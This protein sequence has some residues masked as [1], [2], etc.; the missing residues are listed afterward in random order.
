MASKRA[1]DDVY[2]VSVAAVGHA[3][4]T[5]LAC[6]AAVSRA[7]KS[8]SI[9][10]QQANLC[11][12]ACRYCPIEL[13]LGVIFTRWRL[14][15]ACAIIIDSRVPGR[16]PIHQHDFELMASDGFDLEEELLVLTE[17]VM[18]G[19]CFT[20]FQRLTNFAK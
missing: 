18:S 5:Q 12:G 7:K 14:V 4:R 13:V 3:H 11:G 8:C 1:V 6:G 15:T 19:V 2:H 10:R 9:A 17:E 20:K 16:R